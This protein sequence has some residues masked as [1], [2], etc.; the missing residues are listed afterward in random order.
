[1]RINDQWRIGFVWSDEGPEHLEI[2]DY[3]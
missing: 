2:V 1:L 3:P